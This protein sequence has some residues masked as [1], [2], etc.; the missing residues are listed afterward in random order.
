MELVFLGTACMMPTKE[1]N[2][3]GMLLLASEGI[4][5]DCGEGIQRQLR[6]A[7]VKPTRI[8]KILITHWHGDHVLGLPGLLQTLSGS[9]YQGQLMIFGPK[10]SKLA[11]KKMMS[12]F[13]NDTRL[14]VVIKEVGR[15]KCFENDDFSLH[16]LELDHG[17]PAVGFRFAEKDRRRIDIPVVR[18]L[19]IPDGPLL[20]KLQ[21]G[22]AIEWKGKKVTPEEATVLVKGRSLAYVTDT[23]LSRNCITLAKDVDVLVSEATFANALQE[24]ADTYKHLSV[25]D[26]ASLANSA[27][28]KRLVL[29]HISQ[30][31]KDSDQLLDEAKQLFDQTV[32]AYDLMKIRF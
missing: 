3:A 22:E 29:T 7:G 25:K 24:K 11:A 19:G 21:D 12:W 5:F 6:V 2:H 28:A 18:K 10:G 32:I 13:H 9:G 16:A 30:R 14:D 20:G 31:Y 15:G 8:S 27:G 4:L 26:A 23:A 17:V 1:R